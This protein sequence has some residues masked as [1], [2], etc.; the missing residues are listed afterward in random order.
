VRTD[1]RSPAARKFRSGA[2]CCDCSRRHAA[3]NLEVQPQLVLLQKTLLN[4]EGLG[5]QLD[6]ASRPLGHGQALPRELDERASG[7]GAF[8][9]GLAAEGPRWSSL[10]PQ[11]P[12][13]L[14]QALQS[15]SGAGTELRA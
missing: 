11:L 10:L 8:M 13:L 12:R 4:I 7:L 6:P 1:L 5:R 14:H 15:A 2:C 3:F 9:K